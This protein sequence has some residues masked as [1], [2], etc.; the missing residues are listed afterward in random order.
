M[1]NLFENAKTWR[2]QGEIGLGIA[3]GYLSTKYSV[4]LPLM[5][6]KEYDLIV[7]MDDE[8]KKVQVKTT[9]YKSKYG[10]HQVLLK[11]CGGNKSGNT[12]KKFNGENVDYLFIV[13]SVGELYFIPTNNNTPKT[14]INLGKNYDKYKI[15]NTAEGDRDDS[16]KV[17]SYD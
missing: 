12:E 6:S 10:V 15:G 9:G 7:D 8:L 16:V 3:I 17:V 13:T 14:A 2:H 4:S 1:K 11:T 5:D